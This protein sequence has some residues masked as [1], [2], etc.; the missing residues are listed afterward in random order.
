MGSMRVRRTRILGRVLFIRA[1]MD[2]EQVL[3]IVSTT[4]FG[5]MIPQCHEHGSYA[6]EPSP[7]SCGTLE[8]KPH[9]D[10]GWASREHKDTNY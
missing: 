1:V 6:S 9:T 8:G 7:E 4:D 10:H 5:L 2:T 3:S